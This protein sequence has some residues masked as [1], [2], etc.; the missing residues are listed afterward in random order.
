M[1]L[2]ILNLHLFMLSQI[3]YLFIMKTNEKEN[4]IYLAC[5]V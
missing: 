3:H 5:I 2:G 1:M 4:G